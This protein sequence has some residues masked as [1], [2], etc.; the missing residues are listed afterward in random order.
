MSDDIIV[1]EQH[2]LFSY[3]GGSSKSF[4]SSFLSFGAKRA[5]LAT[6]STVMIPPNTIA[7]RMPIKSAVTPD[8]KAPISFDEPMKIPLTADTLPRM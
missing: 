6:T 3:A 5:V 1:I 4:M 8:S 7:L 2:E